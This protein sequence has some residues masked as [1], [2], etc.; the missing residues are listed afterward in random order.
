MHA[1]TNALAVQH[2]GSGGGWFKS[3]SVPRHDSSEILLLLGGLRRLF[4]GV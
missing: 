3:D 2:D 1:S 4:T